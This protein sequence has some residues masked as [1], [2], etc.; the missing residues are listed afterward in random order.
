[1][2]LN[3]KAEVRALVG[4]I[5]RAWLE[6]RPEDLPG[7]LTDCFSEEVVFVVGP[8]FQVVARGREACMAGYADFVG[9]AKIDRCQLSD[10]E[11]EIADS[12]AIA[13]YGWEM[14]YMIDGEE[15]RESGHDLFVFTRTDGR[16]RAVWRALLPSEVDAVAAP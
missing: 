5:N 14:V 16:W 15:R 12:T 4:R 1:M 6:E 10:P 9:T 3:S 13:S 7:T 11:I 8:A 2:P